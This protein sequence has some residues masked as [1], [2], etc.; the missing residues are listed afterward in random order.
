MTGLAIKPCVRITKLV[1]AM[2]ARRASRL[3]AHDVAAAATLR[4]CKESKKRGE[5]KHIWK[6]DEGGRAIRLS[7]AIKEVGGVSEVSESRG[8][9]RVLLRRGCGAVKEGEAV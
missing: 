1:E 9:R 8:S 2:V 4:S 5:E 7:E 3:A 6:G